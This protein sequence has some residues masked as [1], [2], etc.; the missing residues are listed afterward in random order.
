MGI[1]GLK[2]AV[3]WIMRIFLVSLL[4]YSIIIKNGGLFFIV[5]SCNLVAFLPVII[6]KRFNVEI[7]MYFTFAILLVI[8]LEII[9]NLFGLFTPEMAWLGYD[10]LLHVI[11]T[12]SITMLS[13]MLVLSLQ[14]YK[15]LKL[16]YGFLFILTILIA[17]SLGAFYEIFEFI[18]D[19][20][21]HMNAQLGLNDTMF[22][23]IANFF[24]GLLAAILVYV[25]TKDIN[26]IKHLFIKP[27]SKK[28]VE[29]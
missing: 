24:G 17:M 18:S 22:D 15:K 5:L 4:P 6:Q 9:G 19:K 27:K 20:I 28:R 13:I 1:E 3:A 16:S 7:P 26:K 2:V 12:F 14:Y 29:K 11:S 10:K 25:Y 23:M 21:F 8:Y